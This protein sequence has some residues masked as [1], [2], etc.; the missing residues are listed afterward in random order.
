MLNYPT[1]LRFILLTASFLLTEHAISNEVGNSSTGFIIALSVY[2]LLFSLHEHAKIIFREN[3][4]NKLFWF[5]LFSISSVI[6]C[7]S[8]VGISYSRLNSI[9]L[10][11]IN[12]DYNNYIQFIE[13]A[14]AELSSLEQIHFG[15][16]KNDDKTIYDLLQNLSV[17]INDIDIENFYPDRDIS[18]DDDS[19]FSTEKNKNDNNNKNVVEDK[20][21]KSST[22]LNNLFNESAKYRQGV[23]LLL[24]TQLL[25]LLKR[26]NGN[27]NNCP[28]DENWC[29]TNYSLLLSASSPQ[30]GIYGFVNFK[31]KGFTSKPSLMTLFLA[32]W[33]C[34]E[35]VFPLLLL[36]LLLD[37]IGPLV[38]TWLDVKYSARKDDGEDISGASSLQYKKGYIYILSTIFMP[39][40]KLNKFSTNIVFVKR[41]QILYITI[42]L[43]F[44]I[45]FLGFGYWMYDRLFSF[46]DLYRKL[47]AIFFGFSLSYALAVYGIDFVR[48]PLILKDKRHILTH[49]NSGSLLTFIAFL[50]LFSFSIS[51]WLIGESNLFD[52]FVTTTI[53]FSTILFFVILL[54]F[55]LNYYETASAI[56]IFTRIVIL[57]ISIIIVA[58]PIHLSFL[59]KDIERHNEEMLKEKLVPDNS[60]IS[61]VGRQI[62]NIETIKKNER[63]KIYDMCYS[64]YNLSYEQCENNDIAIKHK[65]LV[66]DIIDLFILIEEN[67]K[68]KNDKTIQQFS[69][70]ASKSQ[71]TEALTL[72]E[73][74]PTEKRGCG[75]KCSEFKIDLKNIEDKIKDYE[76]K[77]KQCLE[78]KGKCTENINSDTSVYNDLLDSLSQS[79][80]RVTE[81]KKQSYEDLKRRVSDRINNLTVLDRRKLIDE[82][83]I[84]EGT[85]SIVNT[86]LIQAY[87]VASFLPIIFIVLRLTSKKEYE[88]WLADENENATN[89]KPI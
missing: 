52:L 62:A 15:F 79:H 32:L 8:T 1:L 22:R 61:D 44:I 10:D 87:G 17:S 55:F 26:I 63:S 27:S 11:M 51:A 3:N 21:D 75:I 86:V 37:L 50:I 29:Q 70:M 5:I 83:K 78:I 23:K 13:K 66:K 31:P 18:D 82:M 6:A 73:Y 71:N 45:D 28:Y 47:T 89:N 49:Y 59:K 40:N 57:L 74:S 56:I 42:L 41:M 67:G 72:L 85:R 43:I 84:I 14:K 46:P 25:P 65:S 64:K 36:S 35:L 76:K 2:I 38:I 7:F 20:L 88:K 19:I 53:V 80:K 33:Y 69:D 60:T 4:I 77:Q 58:E 54:S 30:S 34:F 12:D 68:P 48:S 16:K 39:S 81:E 24:R 9:S